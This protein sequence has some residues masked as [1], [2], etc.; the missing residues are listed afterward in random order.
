MTQ[1]LVGDQ[2]PGCIPE[3]VLVSILFNFINNLHVC[4]E[5]ALR[6]FAGD[7]N[8]VE[9]VDQAD[10]CSAVQRNLDRLEK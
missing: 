6:K 8:L 5:C 3:L 7:T 10:G 9:V 2:S 1:R 4:T